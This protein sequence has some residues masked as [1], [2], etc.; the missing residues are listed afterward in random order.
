MHC[1]CKHRDLNTANYSNAKL[2]LS[3]WLQDLAIFVLCIAHEGSWMSSERELKP[4]YM[5]NEELFRLS[6]NRTLELIKTLC[7]CSALWPLL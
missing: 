1:C 6:Q 4:A 3:A 5:Q 2:V 7:E